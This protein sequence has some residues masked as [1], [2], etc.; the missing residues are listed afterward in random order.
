MG[1]RIDPA[2]RAAHQVLCA[3]TEGGQLMAEALPGAVAKL[4]PAERAR[5]Q[6]LAT[7]TFRWMDRADRMLGPYLRQRPPD[8]TLNALR[9]GCVEICHLQEAPYG[10]VDALV[11]LVTVVP[12]ARRT[13][14]LVNALL[15]SVARDKDKWADLPVPRAPKWLRKKLIAAYGKDVVASIE[16][17]HC[18]GAP[19]DLSAKSDPAQVAALVGG[20]VVPSGSVRVD[21]PVEVTKLAGFSTGDWWVQDAAAALP[22]RLLAAQKGERILDLCAAPGGKTMQMA[23]RGAQVTALD[24]APARMARL[25]ENMARTGLTCTPVVA[26]ALSYRAD[27]FDAVLVDA[28]CSATGTIRR[29]PELPYAKSPASIEPLIGLQAKMLDHARH[30]VKAGGRMVFCTC[31]LLP[32]EGEAQIHAFVERHKDW[33]VD[34][35]GLQSSGVDPTWIGQMGVRVRPDYWQDIGGLD[36]FFISLLR[37]SA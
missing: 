17:A 30:L 28:P 27:P 13:S 18:A 32:E 4:K 35:A 26:D 11:S 9:L 8:A 12:A 7:V 3:V 29:H 5:A 20:Q 19:L 16:L 10:V 15:R 33:T 31:S 22:A 24:D 37:K 34:V 25:A 14:G 1:Q 23:A 6:R 21:G 2:R 36:G